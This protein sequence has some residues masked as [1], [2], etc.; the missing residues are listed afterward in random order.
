MSPKVH[1]DTV[2]EAFPTFS[3]APGNWIDVLICGKVV[4]GAGSWTYFLNGTK[5]VGSSAFNYDLEPATINS[6]QFAQRTNTE[7]MYDNVEVY[8]TDTLPTF[9]ATDVEVDEDENITVSFSSEISNDIKNYV[10]W[11]GKSIAPSRLKIDD[12]KTKLIFAAPNHEYIYGYSYPLV[13]QEGADSALGSC[14]EEEFTFN[15]DSLGTENNNDIQVYLAND[16]QYKDNKYT[17]DF[18]TVNN[19]S[20]EKTVSAIL[21]SYTDGVLSKIEIQPLTVPV[22]ASVETVTVNFTETFATTQVKVFVMDM[23]NA[24]PYFSFWGNGFS[25]VES[26]PDL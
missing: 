26:E 11:N 10:T 5:V 3:S 12:T 21:A 7:A 20:A 19:T 6:I 25:M 16:M 22:S 18:N 14:T 15:I 13:V 9:E 2:G 8:V 17:V 1:G 24:M 23:D 4:N